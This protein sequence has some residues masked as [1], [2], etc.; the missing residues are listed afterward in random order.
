[1]TRAKLPMVLAASVLALGFAAC[2]PENPAAEAV[3]ADTAALDGTTTTETAVDSGVTNFV[4]MSSV[5][6]DGFIE[7]PVDRSIDEL[8][9]GS[10]TYFA[11]EDIIIAN[12]T[13]CMENG[14]CALARNLTNGIG[15]G[16][17]EF[18]V[19]RTDKT[20]L[21]PAYAFTY[22]NRKEVRKVAE[23]NMTGSSGHRRV[24]SDF[25]SDLRIPLPPLDT[26]QKLVNECEAIEKEAS[27]AHAMV[28]KAVLELAE[29]R[30]SMNSSSERQVML[31]AVVDQFHGGR[32]VLRLHHAP[33]DA[34]PGGRLRR[35]R[36][37]RPGIG[38]HG[39]DRRCGG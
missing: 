12:I 5:S 8:R 19:I 20:K 4:E 33:D 34:A 21:L 26:Q 2:A 3:P 35:E 7:S 31:G 17:S 32:D 38:R 9:K 15:M 14:K 29:L 25:Y 1:M 30:M 24:P 16:S 37:R 27:E 13:P 6:S 39:R 18:H 10:F 36:G 22:I 23:S 11:D 28:Q